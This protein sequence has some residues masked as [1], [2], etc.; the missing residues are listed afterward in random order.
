MKLIEFQSGTGTHC[1]IW[2]WK[3]QL[4]DTIVIAIDGQKVTK[5]EDVTKIVAEAI[6]KGKSHVEIEFGSLAGL[7]MNTNG[8]PT[9]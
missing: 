8:I 5:R 2:A 1:H 9:F 3:Q 7:A 6:R 4:K